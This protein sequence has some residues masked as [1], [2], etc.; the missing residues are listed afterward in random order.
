[1]AH[2]GLCLGGKRPPEEKRR[3]GERR[4]RRRGK[5]EGGVLSFA[6][7]RPVKE[8]RGLVV[9]GK[10]EG[11]RRG[12]EVVNDKENGLCCSSRRQGVRKGKSAK[13]LGLTQ[14]CDFLQGGRTRVRKRALGP[15]KKKG[16]QS[17]VKG[18]ERN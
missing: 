1:V 13:R 12:R 9:P 18:R 7:R 5:S 4:H 6:D 10:S 2:A 17:S 8:N 16:R 15:L 14:G 11:K 3:K